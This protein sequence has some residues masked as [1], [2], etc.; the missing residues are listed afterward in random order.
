MS[1]LTKY[2]LEDASGAEDNE[3]WFWNSL[4]DLHD[5]AKRIIREHLN[6]LGK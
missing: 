2:G 4:A 5:E 1:Q 3:N 6:R